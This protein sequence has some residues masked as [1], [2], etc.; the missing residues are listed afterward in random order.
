MTLGG[1]YRSWSSSLCSFLH[2][3]VASSLLGP[4]TFLSTLFSKHP[5]PRSSVSVSDQVSHPYT[6]AGKTMVLYI[7]ILITLDSK[8]ED[9]RFCTERQQAFPDFS[10]LLFSPWMQCWFVGVVPK[11]LHCSTHSQDIL[12]SMYLY[13]F[14]SNVTVHVSVCTCV[15]L[16]VS[17]H[18]LARIFF[19]NPST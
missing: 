16:T 19:W 2:S 3:P 6:T 7:L 17:Q 1:K 18:L 9:R 14:V 11:Y 5:Q 13:S 4:C 10:L 15:I 12:Y 8:L